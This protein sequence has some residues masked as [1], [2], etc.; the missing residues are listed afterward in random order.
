[1][2][3]EGV[4]D[5]DG[6]AWKKQAFDELEFGDRSENFRGRRRE[7]RNTSS[8]NFGFFGMGFGLVWC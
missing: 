7:A 1:M 2:N 5:D 6:G 4:A 3:S 8:G